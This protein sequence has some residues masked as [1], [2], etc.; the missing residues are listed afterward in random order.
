MPRRTG[1]FPWSGR[2]A[3]AGRASANHAGG[4]TPRHP[5][6][7]DALG[8]DDLHHRAHGLVEGL[9]WL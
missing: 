3:G 8:M 9:A 2:H 5:A 1:I 4:V 6:G 7:D